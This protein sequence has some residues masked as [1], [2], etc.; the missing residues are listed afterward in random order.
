MILRVKRISGLVGRASRVRRLR[1]LAQLRA[2]GVARGGDC[3]DGRGVLQS[4]RVVERLGYV[5]RTKKSFIVYTILILPILS[6]SRSIL[7]LQSLSCALPVVLS[8][9]TRSLCDSI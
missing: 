1:V 8:H 2:K 6:L 5:F 3:A 7:A 9:S 4:R